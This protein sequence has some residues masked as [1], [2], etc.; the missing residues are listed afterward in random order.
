MYPTDLTESQWR[1]L[2]GHVVVD[3][4]D[5]FLAVMV[6][7]ASSIHDSKAVDLLLRT[8]SYFLSPV[9]GYPC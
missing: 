1:M 9:K 4:K 5:S 8:L 6:T 3:K 2:P 7:V